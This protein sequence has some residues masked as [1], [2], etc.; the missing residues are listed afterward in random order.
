M[1]TIRHSISF[2]DSN[3]LPRREPLCSAD[4]LEGRGVGYTCAGSKGILERGTH[5]SG[6]LRRR[7]GGKRREARS[8]RE[9]ED[10]DHMG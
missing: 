9:D 2:N 10:E 3:C 7:D 5:Q 8:H 4:R 1:P 6:R